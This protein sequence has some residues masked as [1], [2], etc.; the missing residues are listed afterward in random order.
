MLWEDSQVPSEKDAS[1]DS[2]S[3]PESAVNI[4]QWAEGVP[5]DLARVRCCA[6]R[7]LLEGQTPWKV[8]RPRP[9]GSA[10]APPG[11]PTSLSLRDG[12]VPYPTSLESDSSS[13][14]FLAA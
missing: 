10:L 6:L 14:H 9:P 8:R 11:P 5:R 2:D 12:N 7:W 3:L 13:S 4:T 1:T